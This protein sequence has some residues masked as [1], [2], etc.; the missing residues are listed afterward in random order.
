[1]DKR[2]VF[3]SVLHDTYNILYSYNLIQMCTRRAMLTLGTGTSNYP[4]ANMPTHLNA[5]RKR[6]NVDLPLRD[7]RNGR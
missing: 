7:L 5:S 3:H 2:I 6:P 1:M 4:G